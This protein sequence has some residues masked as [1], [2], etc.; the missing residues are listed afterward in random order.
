MRG[1]AGAGGG[2]AWWESGC[3]RPR[4]AASAGLV[5]AALL[6]YQAFGGTAGLDPERV[7]AHSAETAVVSVVH[8]MCALAAGAGALFLAR[9]G[10]LR[11]RWPLG[12]AWV[13]A[14]AT[15]SWGTW[16]LITSVGPQLDGGEGPSGAVQLI[17]AGQMVTGS[18]AAAVLTRFLISRRES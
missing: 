18:L 8:G 11:A 12:L 13:G 15:L 5:I 2:R 3:R 1:S 10:T 17:Y 9:G 6:A 14:G 4:A 16:M 7:A